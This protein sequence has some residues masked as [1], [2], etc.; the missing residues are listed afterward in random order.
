MS[1]TIRQ[2]NNNNP[3]WFCRAFRQFNGRDFVLPY[4][5]H[6]L[7]ALVAPRLLYIASASGDA[8]A[9][10]WGEFLTA[11]HASPVWTLYGKDGL[12]EDGPYRI[13]VPFHVGRVGYHLRKGDHDLTLY[14]WSRFMDFADRHLR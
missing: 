11:R 10:P 13:E 12:V 3:H 1:E 2:D 9:G 5:Q 8:G 7:A 14:D 4:D 6:W